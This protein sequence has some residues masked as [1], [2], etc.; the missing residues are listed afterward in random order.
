MRAATTACYYVVVSG[1]DF[2]SV[3][4]VWMLLSETC[5]PYF[6]V[7]LTCVSLMFAL[8]EEKNRNEN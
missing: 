7:K 2:K 4:V 8:K 1:N 3:C 6:R 5:W